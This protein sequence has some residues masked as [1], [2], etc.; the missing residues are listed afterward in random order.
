MATT[1][2]TGYIFD[3]ALGVAAAALVATGKNPLNVLNV[4]SVAN[5]RP[6]WLG[7]LGDAVR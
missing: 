7:Q 4:Y 1:T 3:T 5:G 6:M 2:T